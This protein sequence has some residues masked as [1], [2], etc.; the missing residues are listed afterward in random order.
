MKKTIISLLLAGLLL[1]GCK[2]ENPVANQHNE[3]I[4]QLTAQ[5]AELKAQ[6][7][8]AEERQKGLIP[9]L[10]LQ[11]KVIFSQTEETTTEDK[12]TVSTT[13]TIT[14]LSDSGQDWLDQLLLR[15]FEPQQTNLTNREQLATFYQQEFNLD[16]TEDAFNQELSKTLNF[17]SQRGKL[18]L[19]SLRTYSYSGG[20]H[21]MYRTQYLNIDLARQRLL[22]FNDV[23]KADSRASL[24]AALWDIYTQYGAIHEDEVFTNKQDFNVPD[25]FYLAIDGVHFVYELYEIAS[26]AEGEQELVIGWSQLQDW[27]TEDFKA[28]GYFVTKQ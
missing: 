3:Q 12:R 14:G 28:A 5:V 7:A 23:F 15:Q 18:A 10:V 19:F 1:G 16:K 6:L 9:A 11:P 26:F 2:E 8:Q 17:L 13:F 25:N 22:T 24:K 4:A 20:A 21:G 27:L